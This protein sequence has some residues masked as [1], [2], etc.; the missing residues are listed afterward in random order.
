[1]L[2]TD[3]FARDVARQLMQIEGD[4]QTLLAGH[5]AITFDLVFH[6]SVWSH[7]KI[8]ENTKGSSNYPEGIASFSPGLEV[9]AGQARSDYPG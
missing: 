2:A 9:R 4:L 5:L 6:C 7:A 3:A 1:M 8:M